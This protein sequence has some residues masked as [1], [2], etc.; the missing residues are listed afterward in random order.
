[1][2]LVAILKPNT[3]RSP[4]NDCFTNASISFHDGTH[5]TVAT[6][7]QKYD[8]VQR[9]RRR[10]LAI[11]SSPTMPPRRRLLKTA[12]DYWMSLGPPTLRTR[13]NYQ[14]NTE[15]REPQRSFVSST[16]RS[17]DD[18]ERLLLEP[19]TL[20]TVHTRR[21]LTEEWLELPTARR[22]G[23]NS[24]DDSWP[25]DQHDSSVS[26]SKCLRENWTCG[27]AA[28]NEEAIVANISQ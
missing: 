23:K 7:Q 20:Q 9:Y 26:D 27:V 1:M 3:T 21:H 16:V 10:T 19:K 11:G 25:G 5:A 15:Q 18:S 22:S 2:L 17:H 6:I 14:T 13:M 28:R 24:D 12:T 4:L 8:D